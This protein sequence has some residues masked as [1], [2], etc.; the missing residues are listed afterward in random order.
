MRTLLR[1]LAF[2]LVI[3]LP[4]QAA[5]PE[6]E[7]LKALFTEGIQADWFTEEFLRAVPLPQVKALVAG[8]KLK[9]GTLKGVQREG[10]RYLLVFERGEVPASITLDARG[11][12]AGLFFHPP[13]KRLASLEEAKEAYSK[14]PGKLHFLVLKDVSPLIGLNP[15]ARLAVG[16][17]F[18]L[19]V[20]AA[21][22]DTVEKGEHAWDEVVPL[23]E[24]WKSLP[25]GEL[26]SW[27]AGTPLTLASLAGRMM[28]ESDNTA[29]DH[30]IHALGRERV[31]R[32]A[33]KNTPLLT[34]KA[35]FVLRA[36]PK[37]A[38]R[39]K[40]A[41]PAER[42]NILREAE[43]R[44]LPPIRTLLNAPVDLVLEWHYTAR[45]LCTLAYAALRTPLSGINPGLA[46]KNAWA[47][48]AFKGGSEPGVLNLTTALVGE[49]GRRYCAVATWNEKGL[50]Q[51]R[52]FALYG[53]VLRLLAETAP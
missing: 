40:Q 49:A 14:L 4:A 29:T 21:L 48:I 34:T 35:L 45:E 12:I 24:R 28:A 10:G 19:S 39:Y 36:D 30:L 41:D 17:A 1:C 26:Q 46:D 15:Y 31:E 51:D 16:S 33:F 43:A 53:G 7:R 47:K 22:L 11:R 2:L 38:A 25:S 32:F 6:V 20:L 8:L 44:P 23:K 5:S 3:S 27:P 37:L 13:R 9:L 42:R 52:F 18:K 50:D